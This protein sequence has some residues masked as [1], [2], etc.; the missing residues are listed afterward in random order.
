M[1]L[2]GEFHNRGTIRADGSQLVAVGQGNVF[3]EFPDDSPAI[4]LT[5]QVLVSIGRVVVNQ[6]ELVRAAESPALNTERSESQ[7]IV[8]GAG[9][10]PA[11][12][13]INGQQDGDGFA[14]TQI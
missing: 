12:V 4:T 6:G 3:N 5:L 2:A 1:V 11:D 14:G 8:G 10:C 9:T 13:L 7:Q